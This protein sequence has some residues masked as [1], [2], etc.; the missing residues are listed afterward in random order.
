[1]LPHT[2]RAIVPAQIITMRDGEFVTTLDVIATGAQLPKS[3]VTAAALKH[4]EDLA[5]FGPVDFKTF[6]EYQTALLMVWLPGRKVAIFRLMLSRA[7]RAT[8]ELLSLKAFH[9][10]PELMRDRWSPAGQQAVNNA[11]VAV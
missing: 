6:N 4:A 11:M 5:E 8:R 9:F 1:M 10:H 3:A 7:F 2:Q